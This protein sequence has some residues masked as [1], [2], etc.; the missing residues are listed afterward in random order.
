MLH[1]KLHA[2]QILLQD[3]QARGFSLFAHCSGPHFLGFSAVVT[4]GDMAVSGCVRAS[5]T[6]ADGDP[7][8]D[9]AD[10]PLAARD[11]PAAPPRAPAPAPP[12]VLPLAPARLYWSPLAPSCSRTPARLRKCCSILSSSAMDELLAGEPAVALAAFGFAL[13]SLVRALLS[14]AA[15]APVAPPSAASRTRALPL[16]LLALGFGATRESSCPVCI[17][18]LFEFGALPAGGE[19]G[20]KLVFDVVSVT[21]RD[22]LFGSRLTRGTLKELVLIAAPV[23]A[24]DGVGET[25]AE[26]GEL[27]ATSAR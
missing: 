18:E 10:W 14:M 12:P 25:L 15:A 23:D 20:L 7:G 22:K 5:G 21:P 26:C 16:P 27:A 6:S 17:L 9:E 11:S 1:C 13:A 3:F 24:V 2:D 4:R 19:M 8:G